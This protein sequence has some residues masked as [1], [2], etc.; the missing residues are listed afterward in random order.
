MPMNSVLLAIARRFE[1]TSAGRT[2]QGERDLLID[3]EKLLDDAGCHDGDPRALA[4][5]ELLQAEKEG[6]ILLERQRLDPAIIHR[7]R[8]PLKNHERL[9]ERLKL[10]HP[11]SKRSKLGDLFE[12]ASQWNVPAE[13]QASWRG[14]CAK[15]RAAAVQGNTIAPFSRDSMVENRELLDILKRLL[16]WKGESLVR[17]ASCVLCGESKRLEALQ[18]N[19]E[20][21]LDDMSGGAKKRLDDFGI[22]ETPRTCLIHGPLRLKIGQQWLDLGVL[23]GPIRLSELDIRQAE[24]LTTPAIRCV[25]IENETTFQELAKLRCGDLLIQTSFPGAAIR[26]LMGRLPEALECWHFGDADPAG[27]DVL[28]D[29]RERTGRPI[30]SL[31]MR[32]RPGDTATPLTS[33]EKRT[34]ATLSR[35]PLMDAEKPELEKMLASKDKGQFEQESLGRPD[36]PHWPYYK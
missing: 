36:L 35:M 34:L 3:F 33:Q 22:V 19:L 29:L 18:F 14:Y 13:W 7:V 4:I 21:A 9:F 5:E 31:H 17:F 15:L 26:L 12:E 27:F 16:E 24:E 23:T 20:R 10:E 28:R 1:T 2:G 30:R 25:T 6:L 32:H 11:H 8:L